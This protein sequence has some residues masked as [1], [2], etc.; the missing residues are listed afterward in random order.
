MKSLLFSC[1]FPLLVSESIA[2]TDTVVVRAD[3]ICNNFMPIRSHIAVATKYGPGSYEYTDSVRVC[4]SILNVYNSYYYLIVYD[5]NGIKR[6]EGSFYDGYANGHCVNYDVKG[7]I[8][9]EG[10]YKIKGRH[11]RKY[12]VMSGTW[13]YYNANGD[14]IRHEKH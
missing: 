11:K 14:L 12:S 4:D 3:S 8:T 7:R 2:Q 6:L 13:K 9:S 5:K 1:L 10:D